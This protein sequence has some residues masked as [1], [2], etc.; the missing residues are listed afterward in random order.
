MLT[1]LSHTLTNII[2]N[3]FSGITFTSMIY[4]LFLSL[5]PVFWYKYKNKS[6]SFTCMLGI[7]L[8]SFYIG[9][10]FLITIVRRELGSSNGQAIFSFINLESF[11]NLEYY[12]VQIVLYL[13]LCMFLNVILFVPFGFLLR[14]VLE[15]QMQKIKSLTV[16]FGSLA[17]T[18]CIETIQLFTGTGVFDIY[19]IFANTLGGMIGS[20]FAYITIRLAKYLQLYEPEM[21]QTKYIVTQ[22]KPLITEYE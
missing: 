12:D 17:L 3:Q 22:G 16:L 1:M 9:I 4:I 11:M 2:Q 20:L 21:T 10:I 7:Y 19:D 14:A 5:L 8:T 15:K 6:L 18:L 13:A